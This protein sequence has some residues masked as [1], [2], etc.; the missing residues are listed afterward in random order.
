MLLANSDQAIR[1]RSSKSEQNLYLVQVSR[2][3]IYSAELRLNSKRSAT[4]S[5]LVAAGH[6]KRLRIF[7]KDFFHLVHLMLTMRLKRAVQLGNEYVPA[8]SIEKFVGEFGSK[9]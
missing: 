3:L 2:R 6:H 5:P 4:E 7:S 9:P 8:K 1:S